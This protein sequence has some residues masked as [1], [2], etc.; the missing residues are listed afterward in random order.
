M[1][2]SSVI[3]G[4]DEHLAAQVPR[5]PPAPAAA[6]QE[7]G[8]WEKIK[9]ALEWARNKFR[10]QGASHDDMY[11]EKI[12]EALTAYASLREKPSLAE[13]TLL[14]LLAMI[15][16]DGGHYHARH[17]LQKAYDDAVEIVASLREKEEA[18][19]S[20]EWKLLDWIYDQFRLSSDGRSHDVC[21]RI[22]ALRQE[23]LAA[24][25][26]ATEPNTHVLQMAL[27]N[28]LSKVAEQFAR[29]DA[30]LY[31][32]DAPTTVNIYLR[33]M[34][35]AVSEALSKHA[36]KSEEGTEKIWRER[37]ENAS[38]LGQATGALKALRF[39]VTSDIKVKIDSLLDDLAPSVELAPE[40]SS[41]S[42]LPKAESL[43]QCGHIQAIHFRYGEPEFC[44]F[45]N[46]ECDKFSPPLIV[47]STEPN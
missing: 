40:S 27:E 38:K 3:G 35:A 13:R 26:E 21:E 44:R 18:K 42:G 30:N 41:G 16:G 22:R 24:R 23:R 6:G 5:N 19:P 7:E 36:P 12:E 1:S 9:T 34:L 11:V 25:K 14:D 32:E 39:Y 20:E 33:P 29:E 28:K 31:A 8:E 45:T 15:H 37:I 46:C 10:D 17:G 4:N 47:S 43:C 2:D